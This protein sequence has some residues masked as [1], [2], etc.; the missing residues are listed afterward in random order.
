MAKVLK[1]KKVKQVGPERAIFRC[2]VCGDLPVQHPMNP[3]T[4]LCR[5]CDLVIS[6][7]HSIAA[8]TVWMMDGPACQWPVEIGDLY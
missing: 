5:R 7:L 6:P 3:H 2:G 4:L 1:R 8:Y